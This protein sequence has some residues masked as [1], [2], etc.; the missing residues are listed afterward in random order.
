MGPNEGNSTAGG[1][2]ASM[3][4]ST[5]CFED[6]HKWS[7]VFSHVSDECATAPETVWHMNGKAAVL[8]ALRSIGL[9]AAEEVPGKSSKGAKWEADVLFTASGRVI[10]IELQRSYQTMRDFLRRQERYTESGVECFWL[11]RQEGFLTLLKSTSR[12]VLKRDHGGVFPTQGIGTGALP[13]LPIALL[14]PEAPRPVQFGLGKDATVREWL[15][16]I[17]I[18]EFRHREGAWS[19][20]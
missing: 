6:E 13:E 19:I 16:A 5:C 4:S 1:V 8:A 14:S 2:R 11:L 12:L 3:L 15:E 10:A 9:D 7:A 20:R 17:L 18:G